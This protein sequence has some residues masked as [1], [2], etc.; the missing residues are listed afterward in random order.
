APKTLANRDP[1]MG[2]DFSAAMRQALQLIRSQNVLEATR[3]IH[4]AL[5]DRGAEASP[6]DDLGERELILLPP[7]E[8]LGTRETARGASEQVQGAASVKGAGNRQQSSGRP[9]RPLRE[10]VELLRRADFS[11]LRRGS[12]PS[13]ELRRAPPV[14]V[15]EGAAY[16]TRTFACAAGARDY[17]VY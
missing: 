4:G 11:G 6:T 16:L 17:K 12:G 5:A 2:T 7:P 10:V 14:A 1:T 8:I 15:P 13:Q 9:R 3:V